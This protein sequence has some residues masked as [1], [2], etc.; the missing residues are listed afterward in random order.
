VEDGTAKIIKR[1]DE[2]VTVLAQAPFAYDE[3]SKLQFEVKVEGDTV[4]FAIDGKTLLAATDGEYV[5]GGAGYFI[6]EGTIPALG[7]EVR[8]I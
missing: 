6:E 5:S 4:A 3:N 2:V 7:F 1:R 8:A